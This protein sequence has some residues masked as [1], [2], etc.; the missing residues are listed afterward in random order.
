MKYC[1]KCGT[2]LA[3]VEVENKQRLKCPQ[4]SCDYVFWDNPVPVVAAIVE[5]ERGVILVRN[6]SWPPKMYGLVTGF[7]EKGET[8]ET[9]VLRLRRHREQQRRMESSLLRNPYWR[10]AETDVFL[11]DAPPDIETSF[12]A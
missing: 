10:V 3:L 5:T 2:G 4:P 11:A 9:A 1:P 8:P 6:R 7:L 12:N